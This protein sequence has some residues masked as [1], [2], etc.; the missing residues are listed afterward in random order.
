MRGNRVRG[1]GTM[2]GPADRAGDREVWRPRLGR[3]VPHGL[4]PAVVASL[5]AIGYV[6]APGVGP[7]DMA[8]FGLI[9]LVA[10]TLLY[11]AGRPRVIAGARGLTVVNIFRRRELE[12]AEVVGASMP[13]GEPWPTFDLADGTT[14]AVMG[15]QAADG[16]RGRR[17]FARLQTLLDHYSDA[18]SA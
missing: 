9:G 6:M 17:D 1:R 15:I 16:A 14:L 8:L 4:I 3:L 7:A 11:L 2:G 12:W 13:E 10:L 5:A 18:S